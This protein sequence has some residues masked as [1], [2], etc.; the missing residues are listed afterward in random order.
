MTP[1][2]TRVN[3]IRRTHP[4]AL[5]RAVPTPTSSSVARATSGTAHPLVRLDATRGGVALILA[6]RT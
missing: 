6:L 2:I 1:F 4:A 5:A 3:E